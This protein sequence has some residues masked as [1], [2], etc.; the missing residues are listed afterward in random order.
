MSRRVIIV[1]LI[2]AGLALA[3]AAALARG[4]GIELWTD[5]GKDAVYQ[6]GDRMQVKVR[7]S[8][9]A[10]LLVY[11]I[12][13]E[14]YVHVLYPYQGANGFVEG[15]RTLRV[16]DEDAQV[17][18]VVEPTTG[19]AYIVAIAADEPFRDLPWYLRAYDARSEGVEYE[20]GPEDEEG[21]TSEGRI[22]GD[23]FVAME[24]IRRQV[25]R[26]AT[27]PESFATAYTSY[28]VHE[29]VRYPRYL[30]YDCHRPNR[31]AWWDG[32][33]PYYTTCSVVDFRINWGWYWGPSY[34]FG[35]VPYFVY[36]TRPDCPP[37]WRRHWRNPWYSSWDGW[38]RWNTLWGGP[39]VRYKSPP[40]PG[41]RPPNKY[42]DPSRWRDGGTTPPG[43]IVGDSPRARYRPLVP[44]GRNREAGEVERPGRKV[45]DGRGTVGR[46]GSPSRVPVREVGPGDD[47]PQR[48]RDQERGQDVR[49]QAPRRTERPQPSAPAREERA[50]REE[51]RHERPQ[52]SSP[53]AREERAPREERR[54]E[55]PRPSSPPPRE[56]RRYEAPRPSS[57]PPREER[58]YEAPR[59]SSQRPE[60][61]RPSR[62]EQGRSGRGAR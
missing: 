50:P 59:S 34:W 23:P 11:E 19:E 21:V 31:W 58:R 10:Y 35:R 12:D 17:E 44:V 52:P 5:R 4:L 26:L 18:L 46:S 53:P 40:P 56:E 48:N 38:P 32:F 20:G 27:D 28:Y 1:A 25:L 60:A 24:R 6:P 55:A 36:I 41:Y 15:R 33:D 49:G 43:F 39:L 16:P 61:S 9:D 45:D 14:G 57:P 47:G 54:Y 2:A 8:D 29:R 51:R 3:P 30:C 22:V 13:T 42:D 37:H 7:T 62:G